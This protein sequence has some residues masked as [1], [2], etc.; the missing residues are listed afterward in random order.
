MLSAFSAPNCTTGKANSSLSHRRLK[1]LPPQTHPPQPPGRRRA[2]LWTWRT[3]SCPPASD[4]LS[5]RG[6]GAE[7][8]AS[9]CP[10]AGRPGRSLAS[11]PSGRHRAP[12]PAAASPT[13]APKAARN[14][15]PPLPAGEGRGPRAPAPAG[16]AEPSP[17][18][19]GPARRGTE[20]NGPARPPP[21][22]PPA[23]PRAAAGA[24]AAPWS[25]AAGC[26]SPRSR[27]PPPRSAGLPP[28]RHFLPLFQRSG[29]A[30]RRRR[31]RPS[32]CRAAEAG[33]GA[34]LPAAPHHPP[35]LL[36]RSSGG[37][38]PSKWGGLAGSRRRR[39]GGVPPPSHGLPRLRT[40]GG[41]GRRA[42][43][44]I[45]LTYG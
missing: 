14:R 7:P 31:R 24:S 2:A 36:G 8:A 15:Q 35:A 28:V 16:G 10:P 18:Q 37:Q 32:W 22:P 3:P 6:C 20:R 5:H 34:G 38:G 26:S 9:L 21:L 39:R 23:A 17:A 45:A 44:R 43:N 13:V 19:P 40:T 42:Q 25:P 41:R 27:P 29:R 1:H 4:P 30:T 11:P 33:P 12:S